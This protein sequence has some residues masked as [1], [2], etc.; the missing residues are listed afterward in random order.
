MDSGQA[1]PLDP[2]LLDALTAA[3]ADGRKIEAIKLYR[4]A[5]GSSLVEAKGAVEALEAAAPPGGAAS[6][7]QA[8]PRSSMLSDAQRNAVMGAL[9]QGR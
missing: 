3:I 5:T 6:A 7:S 8:T 2:A 4:E 9:G 1:P